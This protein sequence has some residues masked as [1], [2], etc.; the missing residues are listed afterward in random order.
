MDNNSPSEVK[1][2]GPTMGMNIVETVD[3]TGTPWVTTVVMMGAVQMQF[4]VPATQAEDWVKE[5][6]KA[7]TAAAKTA[8]RK[9]SGLILSTEV[10]TGPLSRSDNGKLVR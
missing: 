1:P 7:V 5:Y 10:P 8:L 6:G 2:T 4:S 9:A 3:Q